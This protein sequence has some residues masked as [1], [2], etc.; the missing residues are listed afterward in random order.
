[1]FVVTELPAPVVAINDNQSSEV[2]HNFNPSTAETTFVQT[3]E[4]ANTYVNQLN[5]VML[6][7][8][9]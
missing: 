2:G 7:F 9:G 6:V 8:I 4:D 1:M 3:Y 5:P